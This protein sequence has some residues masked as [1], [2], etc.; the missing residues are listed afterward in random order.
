MERRRAEFYTF[1][2]LHDIRS[3]CA[4]FKH[5]VTGDTC[6][7]MLHIYAAGFPLWLAVHGDG[8]EVSLDK[9]QQ[10]SRIEEMSL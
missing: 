10:P 2:V 9:Q 3:I 8:E 5:S 1:A 7:D 6:N 4:R